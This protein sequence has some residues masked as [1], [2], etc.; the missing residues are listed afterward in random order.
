MMRGAGLI[1]MGY[2]GQ[3]FTWCNN[4]E[5][6]ERIRERLDRAIVNAEWIHE[7]NKAKVIDKLNIGSDHCPLMVQLEKQGIRTGNHSVLRRRGQRIVNANRLSQRFGR[8]IEDQ[9][10]EEGSTTDWGNAGI[11]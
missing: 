9:E 1:D 5:G 3:H 2:N 7:Y 10:E 8:E 4:R 6:T 11:N